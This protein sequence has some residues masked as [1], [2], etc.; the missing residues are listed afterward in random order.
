MSDAP[1]HLTIELEY[2]SAIFDGEVVNAFLAAYAHM[3]ACV[4]ED[5]RRDWRSIP[6]SAPKTRSITVAPPPPD[7]VAQVRAAATAHPSRTATTASS[8]GMLTYE[9]LWHLVEGVAVEIKETG[10]G[11]NANGLALQSPA[12]NVCRQSCSACL[13]RAPPTCRWT[14]RY[15][16][17]GSRT[18]LADAGLETVIAD[19]TSK[20]RL[21]PFDGAILDLD[22]CAARPRGGSFDGLA[23]VAY[24]MYTSGSTGRPKGVEVGHAALAN[25]ITAFAETLGMDEHDRLAAVTTTSFRHFATRA[26][27]AA[28]ARC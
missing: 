22:I 28:D 7:V 25:L 8:G 6:I 5:P 12:T 21:P 23:D 3:L 14:P 10:A 20:T 16:R 27:A 26:A 19:R 4:V 11:R 18:S 13:P 17:K 24:I 15:R 1:E 2:A 9:R